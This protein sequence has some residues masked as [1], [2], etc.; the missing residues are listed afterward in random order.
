MI[1]NKKIAANMLVDAR[2]EEFLIPCLKSI[3]DVVDEIVIVANPDNKN[4]EIMNIFPKVRVAYLPFKD[5]STARNN[6]LGLSKDADYILRVDADEVHFTD[7]LK[8]VIQRMVDEDKDGAIAAF[9]H[10]IK[11]FKHYQSIDG[12][13]I[14]FRNKP[15]LLWEGK[16][17]EDLHGLLPAD[18]LNTNY[19]YHHYGYTKTQRQVWENWM[20]REKILGTKE[21]FRDRDPNTVLDERKVTEYAGPYPDGMKEVIKHGR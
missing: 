13:T 15:G 20:Q 19:R 5:F 7:Q 10:F 18:L 8:A 11:D 3:V 9:Y 6:C 17:D 21:W 14:L 4:A 12:R 2:T 16:V 1:N